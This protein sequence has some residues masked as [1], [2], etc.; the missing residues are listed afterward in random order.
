MLLLTFI[1]GLTL[2]VTM[3]GGGKHVVCVVSRDN[4]ILSLKHP[5][6][7]SCSIMAQ[8]VVTAARMAQLTNLEC[9]FVIW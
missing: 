8:S 3:G 6:L 2:H 9:L 1:L 4:L 5:I 7:L